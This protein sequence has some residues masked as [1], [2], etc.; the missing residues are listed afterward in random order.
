MSTTE[1]TSVKNEVR[2]GQKIY[3]EHLT[4]VFRLLSA[5]YEMQ[6]AGGNV[7]A[8][9][10]NRYLEKMLH[11]TD[12]LRWKYNEDPY[13]KIQI[14]LTES[15][16]PSYQE[17]SHLETDLTQKTE[18]LQGIPSENMLRAGMMDAMLQKGTDPVDLVEQLCKRKY[19]EKLDAQKVILPF[20]EGK[21][22]LASQNKETRSYLLDWACFD[23]TS[24]RM[25]VHVLA[26]EQNAEVEP[27]EKKG[28]EWNNLIALIHD[29]GSRVPAIGILAMV[30][31]QTLETIHPKVLKRVCVGPIYSKRFSEDENPL[32]EL[33][34]HSEK[35]DDFIIV[36]KD[37]IVFSK[38]QEVSG[39]LFGKKFREIFSIPATDID[40]Y[41]NKASIIHRY[42]L[43]PHALLQLLVANRDAAMKYR[44]YKKYTFENGGKV[45]EI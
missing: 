8:S 21:L 16:F 3:F 26:F 34:E 22:S 42:M 11:T 41:D 43:I 29:E 27:L 38:Q 45:Y 15:G 18:V 24:N 9:I 23:F 40:C 12:C 20:M 33:L 13:A 32:T 6:N 19:Y 10:V 39:G 5:C 7:E 35:E 37:E 14:D 25:Y 36:C 17:I 2:S 28:K 4:R 1:D 31:D 44:A 30:I